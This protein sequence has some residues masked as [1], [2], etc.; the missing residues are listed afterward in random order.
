M[1]DELIEPGFL[2]NVVRSVRKY[3]VV[4]FAVISIGDL[5]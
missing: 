1:T 5:Q 3:C 4:E 2:E